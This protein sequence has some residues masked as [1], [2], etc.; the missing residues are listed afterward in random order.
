[1]TLTCIHGK[2]QTTS[3]K[4]AN[5]VVSGNSVYVSESSFKKYANY[6]NFWIF[7][8]DKGSGSTNTNINTSSLNYTR[9][10]ATQSSN[11]NVRSSASTSSS[12]IGSLAKGTKVNVI[13]VNGDWSKISSPVSGWVSIQYLSASIV[14]TPSTIN[15]NKKIISGYKTGTYKVNTNIHVRSGSGTNYKAKTYRQLTSNARA[16]NRTRGNYYYNG[17]LKGV[18][19]NVTNVKGNWGK[20]ASGWICLDY[21]R[22]K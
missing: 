1:M 16:Q 2:F 6:K 4:S 19:C 17:Y 11:L 13:E 12:K 3:R 8:N 21:C 22:K 15:T 7:S 10:V 9:Y 5:V 20:T 14:K 18:T